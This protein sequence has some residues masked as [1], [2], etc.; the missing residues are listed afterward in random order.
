MNSNATQGT[1]LSA[2]GAAASITVILV[3]IL[4]LHGIQI[5]DPVSE[6]IGSLLGYA[7]HY[8]AMLIIGRSGNGVVVTQPAVVESPASAVGKTANS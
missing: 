5:T 7:I 6:A 4:S 1:A 3:W 8:I 2:Y